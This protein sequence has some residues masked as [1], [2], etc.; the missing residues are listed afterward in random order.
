MVIL[1]IRKIKDLGFNRNR[2]N[3]S[4]D[5]AGHVFE[6]RIRYQVTPE[7][8]TVLGMHTYRGRFVK[9]ELLLI[10]RVQRFMC[11]FALIIA[12]VISVFCMN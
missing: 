9:A 8:G 7:I 10:L 11:A 5:F 2:T 1:A 3:R 12:L 6:E 4:G